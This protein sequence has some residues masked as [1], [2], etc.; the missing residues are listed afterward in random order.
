MSAEC[1]PS[2][3]E[4]L[5]KF[6]AL[7][8]KL[9]ATGDKSYTSELLKLA[10]ANDGTED[11][12]SEE[13]CCEIAMGFRSQ[14]DSIRKECRATLE[15][16]M[17]YL[18]EARF[19]GVQNALLR[20]VA[21]DHFSWSRLIALELCDSERKPEACLRLLE[22]DELALKR[23]ALEAMIPH[24]ENAQYAPELKRAALCYVA[25]GQDPSLRVPA[26]EILRSSR[27]YEGRDTMLQL[28]Q[29]PEACSSELLQVAIK[30]LAELDRGPDEPGDAEAHEAK[31]CGALGPLLEHGSAFVREDAA[32]ALGDVGYQ[33][34]RGL[35]V[36]ALT[37][38]PGWP[39]NHANVLEAKTMALN[40][41]GY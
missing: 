11:P 32:C 16:V 27:S 25:I 39:E 24:A 12:L 22:A 3:V 2:A 26:A 35:A 30:G 38:R 36:A 13:A 9:R 18:G 17:Y 14:R 4:D 23:A 29:D 10:E 19:A 15:K 37:K 31:L 1:G 5:A 33:G 40:S 8:Q 41:L 6:L 21:G 28:L 20:M 7:A 34:P